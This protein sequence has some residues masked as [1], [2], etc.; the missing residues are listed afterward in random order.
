MIGNGDHA[1]QIMAE[2]AKATDKLIAIG[3]TRARKKEALAHAGFDGQWD[4]FV[5]PM[6]R[7]LTHISQLGEGVQVCSMA[8]I[9]N[10]VK[11]G[12]HVI[13][14][15]GAVVHHDVELGDYCF[16]APGAQVLGKAKVGEGCW[17]G[18]NAVIVQGSEVPPWTKVRS[19]SVY[20]NDYTRGIHKLRTIPE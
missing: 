20:P 7:S 8:L 16:I 13:V 18:A 11:C 5:S 9:M 12:R 4:R 19:C 6:A 14:N 17:I 10:N 3:N 2:G 1:H 15:C